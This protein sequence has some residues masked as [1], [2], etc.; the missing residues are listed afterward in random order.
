MAPIPRFDDSQLE[1]I[2]KILGET[3]T[4][5]EISAMFHQ[6]NITEDSPTGTMW[7]RLNAFLGDRQRQ[8]GTGNC[9]VAF[10]YKAMT[11]IRY[12]WSLELEIV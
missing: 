11:P 8:D 9:V 2:C 10:L 7:R 6:L 12:T 5:S 3:V 1:W 4:G